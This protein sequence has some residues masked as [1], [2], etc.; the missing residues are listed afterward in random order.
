VHQTL[1]YSIVLVVDDSSIDHKSNLA[2][3]ASVKIIKHDVNYVNV[4]VSKRVLLS[5]KA[6]LVTKLQIVNVVSEPFH[7]ILHIFLQY[8]IMIMQMNQRLFIKHLEKV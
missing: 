1:N 4:Q 8:L 6:S 5:L 7:L 3:E 2:V